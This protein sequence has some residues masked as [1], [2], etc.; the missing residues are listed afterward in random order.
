MIEV[1]TAKEARDHA[2]QE[3]IPQV[4]AALAAGAAGP[5]GNLP[6]QRV[7]EMDTR[8]LIVPSADLAV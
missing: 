2:G 3:V 8:G 4:W 7:Q 1:W 5:V 6:Q